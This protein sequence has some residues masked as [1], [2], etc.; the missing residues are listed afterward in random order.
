M[1]LTCPSSDFVA[2]CPHKSNSTFMPCNLE[3]SALVLR[4]L[5]NQPITLSGLTKKSENQTAIIHELSRAV[6]RFLHR[7][8][9][10]LVQTA[11]E[12]VTGNHV[13]SSR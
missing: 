3:L 5:A 9:A 6:N 12:K 11:G 10:N 2:I 4:E 8:L 7:N 13:T 1:Y